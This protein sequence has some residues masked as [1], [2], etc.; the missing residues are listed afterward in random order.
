VLSLRLLA[1]LPYAEIAR[2]IGKRE[3]AVKMIAYRALEEVRR[4]YNHD[5]LEA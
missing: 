5:P 3:S 2:I 4:R 1:D